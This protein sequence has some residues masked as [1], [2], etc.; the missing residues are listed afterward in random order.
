MT[1]KKQLALIGLARFCQTVASGSL[2]SYI[3]FQLRSFTLPDGSAP[4]TTTVAFQ[5]CVLR[6]CVAIPGIITSTL[7]GILADNPRVGRKR[8]IILGLVTSGIGRMGLGFT[9]SFAGAV[10]WRLFVGLAPGNKAAMRTMIREISGEKFES[11]AVLLLPTA[12]NVGSIV[13]PVLGGFLAEGAVGGTDDTRWFPRWPFALPN[14]VNGMMLVGCA[15]LISFQLRETLTD[16]TVKRRQRVSISIVPRWVE[17]L[18]KRYFQR[19]PKY[20]LVANQDYDLDERGECQTAAA[21]ILGDKHRSV[22]IWTRRLVMTLAARA[23]L[24][25]HTFA[26]PTLMLVFASTPRYQP[27]NGNNSAAIMATTPANMTM[28]EGDVKSNGSSPFA[29]LPLG[30]HPHAPFTFTG[31]LAFKPHDIAAVL[32]IRGAV[33]LLMQLLFF[34]Y[35]RDVFGTLRLYRYAFAVFPVTYFATPYLATVAS[36]TP[37]PLPAAGLR[38]WVIMSAILVFQSTARSLALPA[39]AMLLNA[40]CPDRSVLGTVNGIGQSVSG[41]ARAMG[42]LLLTGWLYGVGLEAGIVGAA[43]WAMAGVAVAAG[44]AAVCVPAGSAVS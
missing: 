18:Y 21:P 17:R 38:L 34:P 44:V 26:Y 33:G 3:I 10:L 7:W 11:R 39:G 30:Y 27:V 37:P 19:Q 20:E 31:G 28:A 32:A 4:S 35:L 12:F 24:V 41:A 14:M 40:A 36:S 16:D 2:Q 25:M 22:S 42:Q 13:G 1:Q 8:V 43:W 6:A 5:L 29:H 23:L 9:R 15:V